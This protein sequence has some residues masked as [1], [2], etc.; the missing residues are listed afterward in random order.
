M[1]WLS[2]VILGVD[3]SA[4]CIFRDSCGDGM[5]D[6]I[7]YTAVGDSFVTMYERINMNYIG[8]IRYSHI[9]IWTIKSNP[10][11]IHGK[12]NLRKQPVTACKSS[13]QKNGLT[14]VNEASMEDKEP[15]RDRFLRH[16]TLV[17]NGF[18][19]TIY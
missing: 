9:V 3:T 11:R 5:I 4:I 8:R 13:N 19:N 16:P 2:G 10:Q 14:H 18:D 6:K 17:L 7:G 1:V 15:H 12:F